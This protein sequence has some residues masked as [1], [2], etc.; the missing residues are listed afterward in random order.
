MGVV[1]GIVGVVVGAVVGVE[2]AVGV[3]LASTVVASHEGVKD[4]AIFST[5]D[6]ILGDGNVAAAADLAAILF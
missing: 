5:V 3:T 4:D 1:A 2:V 6:E